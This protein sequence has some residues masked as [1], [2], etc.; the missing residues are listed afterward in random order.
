MV[1][2]G[3]DR[4]SKD[5][6]HFLVF[7]II[8]FDQDKNHFALCG[9]G[10]DGFLNE[11]DHLRGNHQLFGIDVYIGK[12]AGKIVDINRGMTFLI[13][14]VLLGQVLNDHVTVHFEI[15]DEFQVTAFFPDFNKNVRDDF[16]RHVFGSDKAGSKSEYVGEKGQKQFIIGLVVFESGNTGLQKIYSGGINRR[17]QQSVFSNHYQ[18]TNYLSI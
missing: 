16:F 5:F 13:F 12:A 14:E 18:V 11:V 15:D 7:E 2:N 1:F 4:Y 9:Q 6:R 8:F 10:V 3:F 17:H